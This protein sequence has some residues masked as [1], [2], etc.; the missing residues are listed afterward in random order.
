MQLCIIG[1]GYVGLI[2]GACLSEMG[3][4]VICVDND[5]EKL[6]KLKNGITP[7]YEPGLEELILANVS[8]GRLEFTNDLNYAVKKSIACFIAVGTPSGDDGSCDLSFVLSV[9]N[10]IGKAMSECNEYKIIVD[11]STVPVGTHKLVEEEIKKNYKGEFDVVSNP[12]FLKQGAAVDDFL[13]PDRVVIGSES[14]KAIDIMREIYNPF[15]RTGNPIIIMDIKSAEMTKYAANAFLATKISF[16]NEMANISE[17]VGANADLVRIGM[18]SDKRIGNQFLFHGLGYGGSCFPKDVQ[19]LIKTASDFGIDSD[20]LKA[21]HKVNVNQR[22]VFVNKILKHYNNDIK[23]KTFAVWGL[24]FK[25]RTND[26]RESPAIT[27]INMLLDKG[28]KI[29]AY[30]PKAMETAKVIFGDKIIYSSNSYEALE[31]ADALILITEWNEFKRPS[32]DKIKSKLKEPIIFDGRNQYDKKRMTDRGIK[33][34]SL[35]V[36]K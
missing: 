14:E 3:N 12:E 20:L 22:K 36:A 25:P 11:K 10:D 8:E 2:T 29:K 18:S 5:E 9:A 30:D 1:T 34:I 32:F 21:T 17:K 26:M 6:K 13:K 27:I 35:G 23:N 4:Y 7:L 16:A 19:A 33:Y 28:A 31:N 24:A 15:T